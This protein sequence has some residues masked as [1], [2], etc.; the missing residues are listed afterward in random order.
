MCVCVCLGGKGG[1]GER[2]EVLQSA[3]L[4]IPRTGEL[5]PEE[6]IC[7]GMRAFGTLLCD[8]VLGHFFLVRGVPSSF[9]FFFSLPFSSFLSSFILLP[10][11]LS[12]PPG[13]FS[14]KGVEGKWRAGGGGGKANLIQDS[15]LPHAKYRAFGTPLLIVL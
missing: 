1:G 13:V 8:T 6:T 15:I 11:A 2:P 7:V 4:G 12:P 10:L 14:G 5:T 3:S 9:F